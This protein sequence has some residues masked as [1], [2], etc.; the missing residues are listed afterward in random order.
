MLRAGRPLHCA[1]G[2]AFWVSRSAA[3]LLLLLHISCFKAGQVRMKADTLYFHP[4]LC[5]LKSS[6]KRRS[7]AKAL[8]EQSVMRV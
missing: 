1:L 6:A 3:L 4:G 8:A 5:G 2:V 7:R